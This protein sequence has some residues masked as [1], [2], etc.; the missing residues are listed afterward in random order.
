MAFRSFALLLA[1]FV[2]FACL[3]AIAQTGSEGSRYLSGIRPGNIEDLLRRMSRCGREGRRAGQP[4]AEGRKQPANRSVHSA[5]PASF[6][7]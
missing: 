1:L 2:A 5:M 7:S 6:L 4:G 3:T